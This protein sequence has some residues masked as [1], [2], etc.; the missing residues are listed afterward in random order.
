M[1]IAAAVLAVSALALAAACSSPGGDHETVRG[2]VLEVDGDL[3]SV[4]SFLLRTD[5]GEVLEAAPAPDGDFRFP[6]PHLHDHRR[7]SEPILV[8]LDRSVDPPLAVAIEDADSPAWH[9]G[10]RSERNDPPGA[11]DEPGPDRPPE[12]TTAESMP[13]E[14]TTA[15]TTRPEREGSEDRQGDQP[16]GAGNGGSTSATSD[17]GAASTPPPAA[18][19]LPEENDEDRSSPESGREP[20]ADGPVI[21]LEIVDGKLEGGARQVP[22]NLGDAVTL[23][24][25]GNSQDEVHVHGYDL[26]VHL[27][28][29]A[30]ELRFE[31]SIPGVF[32]VELEGSHTLLIRLEVS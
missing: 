21:D 23:R 22:V 5:D 20:E 14:S 10:E 12:S 18:A 17:P 24:V 11:A 25:S 30:G 27:E 29:G 6:L 4:K 7:T 28:E 3:T 1:R 19:T 15:E 26:F 32:E 8:E 13:A 16:D 9:T 31:A 2:V